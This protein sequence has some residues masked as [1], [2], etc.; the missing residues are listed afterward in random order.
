PPPECAGALAAAAGALAA[1]DDPIE[2]LPPDIRP[3]PNPLPPLPTLA[4]P[5]RPAPRPP[6]LNAP[7]SECETPLN[8][9]ENAGAVRAPA[10]D[11]LPPPLPPPIFRE[12]AK[13][14]PPP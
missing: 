11:W 6:W 9:C 14:D 4:S 3:P 10:R 8:A 7:G 1:P 13:L 2:L 12:P 5:I